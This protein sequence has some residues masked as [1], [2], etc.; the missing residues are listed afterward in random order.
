LQ[1][2]EREQRDD[3]LAIGKVDKVDQSKYSKKANL[4]G[5]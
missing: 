2:E 3:D 4:I 5:R 1:T